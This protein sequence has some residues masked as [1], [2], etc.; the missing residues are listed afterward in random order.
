MESTAYVGGE[1]GYEQYGSGYPGS[2]DH[3]RPPPHPASGHY[4]TAGDWNPLSYR[5]Y[6]TDQVIPLTWLQLL[7][8]FFLHYVV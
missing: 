7:S 6:G 2:S 3:G 8:S 5:G 4:S 1:R